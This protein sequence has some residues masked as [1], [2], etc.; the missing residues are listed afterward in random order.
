MKTHNW[1]LDSFQIYN[2]NEESLEVKFK[3]ED[4]QFT[5]EWIHAEIRYTYWKEEARDIESGIHI[6]KEKNS[7]DDIRFTN[8]YKKHR[9]VDAETDMMLE[10]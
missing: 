9:S 5:N 10:I 4:I 1:V 7:M 3:L 8:P 6:F 2:R